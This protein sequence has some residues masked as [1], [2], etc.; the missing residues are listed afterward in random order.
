VLNGSLQ[1]YPN[2]VVIPGKDVSG[3]E[4]HLIRGECLN[5]PEE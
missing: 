4:A 1:P 2:N 5:Y 3:R